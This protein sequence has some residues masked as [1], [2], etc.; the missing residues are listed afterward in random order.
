LSIILTLGC[1][2]SETLRQENKNFTNLK[3]RELPST[4]GYYYI[5]DKDFIKIPESSRKSVDFHQIPHFL[6]NR[7]EFI[8]YGEN[9]EQ[10]PIYLF[11]H[12]G[13]QYLLNFAEL[14]TS[15]KSEL[16]NYSQFMPTEPL[17]DGFY[18]FTNEFLENPSYS[19]DDFDDN[20]CFALGDVKR[21]GLDSNS[22]N[23][24]LPAEKMGFYIL[25]NDNLQ[26]IPPSVL[27]EEIDI[28]S[29]PT[30]NQLIPTILFQSDLNSPDSVQIYWRRPIIGISFD[31]WVGDG[32]ILE[33]TPSLGA[34]AAGIQEGDKLI[35]VNGT[36]VSA[37]SLDQ[38]ITTISSSCVAGNKIEILILRGTKTYITSPTCSLNKGDYLEYLFYELNPKGYAEFSIGYP[39]YPNN[40]YCMYVP[41][42][43]EKSC[44]LV[45]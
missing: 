43:G 12:T 35:G 33:V 10:N 25:T 19:G 40:V 22:V 30:T 13:K 26:F 21:L 34:E 42:S 5:D 36:D 39:L 9:L 16:F 14:D 45:Q 4:R 27:N 20:F 28:S 44:F 31:I 2:G 3:K 7:A 23:V 37:Y 11:D 15:S 24:D 41:Y 29:I 32:T 8:A 38:I 17:Q 18:C 1:L 6:T